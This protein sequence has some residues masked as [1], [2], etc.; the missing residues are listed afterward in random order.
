[1]TEIRRLLASDLDQLIEVYR[2]AV[3][4]QAT[5][6]YSNAQIEAW[7]N[8]AS[9]EPDVRRALQQGFGLV[10]CQSTNPAII[11]AFALLDPADRLSLLYCRGR[12]SRQGHGRRLVLALE[13]EARRRGERSLRTEASQL[14]RPLLERLGWWIEAEE[15]VPFGGLLFR[16]WRMIRN[17][18]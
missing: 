2:D 18:M 16:R 17:L 15:E 5:G 7:A 4:S 8:H 12:A 11:E 14:S 9:R 10:S 6:L 3:I 1:M 13:T